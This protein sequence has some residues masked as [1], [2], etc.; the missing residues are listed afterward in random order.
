MVTLKETD[1][2]VV[3]TS[4]CSCGQVM[5]MLLLATSQRQLGWKISELADKCCDGIKKVKA[6]SLGKLQN[7]YINQMTIF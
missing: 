2:P 6:F 5:K 1:E 7:I 4:W 3:M